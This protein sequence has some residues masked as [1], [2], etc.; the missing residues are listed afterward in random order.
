MSGTAS[1]GIREPSQTANLR[2]LKSSPQQ[3]C[4]CSHSLSVTTEDKGGVGL[5]PIP[6]SSFSAVVFYVSKKN[7]L[8]DI[9]TNSQAH[10]GGGS[11]SKNLP[12]LGL[13]SRETNQLKKKK[14]M[15]IPALSELRL[16]AA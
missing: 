16:C 5:T 15:D 9:L 2:F 12:D 1:A 4:L 10:T 6:A 13:V 11:Q 14:K 3:P 8:T 7:A